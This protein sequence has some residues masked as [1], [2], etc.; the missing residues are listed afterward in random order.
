[1]L[2]HLALGRAAG[3]I[4]QMTASGSRCLIVAVSRWRW[5][6]QHQCSLLPGQYLHFRTPIVAWSSSSRAANNL[7]LLNDAGTTFQGPITPGTS[8][9]LSNS[10]CTLSAAGA[11][12]S[13]SGTTLTVTLPLS[14]SAFHGA[15]STFGLAQDKRQP[16]QRLDDH[17]HLDHT[18]KPA[19][20]VL[21]RSTVRV[22]QRTGRMLK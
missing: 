9:S 6:L 22:S 8:G 20:Q 4:A 17:R 1:M 13:T 14:F 15:K 18:V 2:R 5:S 16:T 19:S 12:V 21:W 11:S 10:R 7:S 3:T